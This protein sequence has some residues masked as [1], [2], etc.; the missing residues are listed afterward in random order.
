MQCVRQLYSYAPCAGHLKVSTNFFEIKHHQTA[1]ETENEAHSEYEYDSICM[2]V[3]M[4]NSA[5]TPCISR[6]QCKRVNLFIFWNFISF[7]SVLYARHR[8]Y[9]LWLCQI[10]MI[11]LNQKWTMQK[12]KDCEKETQ[13]QSQTINDNDNGDAHK[14]I[15]VTWPHSFTFF[16]A[17]CI[18]II[19]AYLTRFRLCV[20]ARV[21]VF[22]LSINVY[23]YKIDNN[24]DW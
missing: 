14:Y 20:R 23:Y 5:R 8:I 10:R 22:L 21:F 24:A 4:S 7:W 9:I 19:S 13:E 3:H 17:Y 11:F 1:H 18:M 2:Y 15:G 6:T 12:G 16:L